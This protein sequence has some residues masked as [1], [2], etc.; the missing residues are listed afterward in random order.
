MPV[1]RHPAVRSAEKKL[2]PGEPRGPRQGAR[3]GDLLGEMQDGIRAAINLS[4][5]SE[6]AQLFEQFIA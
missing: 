5:G 1:A 2:H 6:H 3:P 4:L